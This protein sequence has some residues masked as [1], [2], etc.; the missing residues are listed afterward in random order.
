MHV[1]FQVFSSLCWKSNLK[2]FMGEGKTFI[3]FC[4]LC[5]LFFAPYLIRVGFLKHLSGARTNRLE[6]YYLLGLF[7]SMEYLGHHLL[8]TT[9]YNFKSL[10]TANSNG[11]LYLFIKITRVIELHLKFLL[12]KALLPVRGFCWLLQVFCFLQWRDYQV[13]IVDFWKNWVRERKI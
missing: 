2:Y 10:W 5:V 1:L 9:S 11:I 7:S 8:G 12:P 3:Q 4:C 13:L 6:G